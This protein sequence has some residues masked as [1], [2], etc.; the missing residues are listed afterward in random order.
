MVN[1][2]VSNPSEKCLMIIKENCVTHPKKGIKEVFSF[3]RF[4]ITIYAYFL[5]I[6][7]FSS[8]AISYSYGM[9]SLFLLLFLSFIFFF[10][11][12]WLTHAARLSSR[13][14]HIGQDEWI[15]ECIEMESNPNF[16]VRYNF[17][18]FCFFLSFFFVMHT[19]S[20]RHHAS[21]FTHLSNW[22]QMF[23]S[24]AAFYI[25]PYSS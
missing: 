15:N 21:K 11:K 22:R 7:F 14:M 17:F 5:L 2:S 1:R 10:G 12:G 25:I 8:F 3:Y 19:N 20:V 16:Y 24:S 18:R 23:T 13:H 6:F 9:A 4:C